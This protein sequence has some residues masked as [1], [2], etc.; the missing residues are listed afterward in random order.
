MKPIRLVFIFSLLFILSLEAQGQSTYKGCYGFDCKEKKWSI[1]IFGGLSILGP[2]QKIKK[3]MSASGLGD[4]GPDISLHDWFETADYPVGGIG[5]S[6]NLAVG[7]ALSKKSSLQFVGGNSFF[8]VEGYD[9]IG[10]GN[11]LLIK[12]SIWTASFNYVFKLRKG[13]DGFNLG[14]VLANYSA[15]AEYIKGYEYHVTSTSSVKAGFN[16][17]YT[18]S[19]IQTKSWFL[20]G[21]VNYTWLPNADIGPYTVEHENGG[22]PEPEIFTSTFPKT[23]VPL[24]HLSFGL[25][26]GFK[27]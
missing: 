15:K 24:S 20:A 9:D 6:W 17:G 16:A 1:S 8:S 27:F 25:S 23:E 18:F 19:L 12:N 11:S 22:Y 2:G 7:Y 21:N 26:T 10:L 13:K 14:P 5:T 3:Q 4:V